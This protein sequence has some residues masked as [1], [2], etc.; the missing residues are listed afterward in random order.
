MSADYAAPAVHEVGPLRGPTFPEVA[1]ER[2]LGLLRT[3]GH[4]VLG[5]MDGWDCRRVLGRAVELG[6]EIDDARR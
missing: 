6:K 1:L 3:N 4:H 5:Q 2:L